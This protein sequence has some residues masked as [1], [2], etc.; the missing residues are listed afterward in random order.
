VETNHTSL[1]AV[2][3]VIVS[4]K[5]FMEELFGAIPFLWIRRVRVFF[6]QIGNVWALLEV[7]RLDAS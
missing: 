1:K 6:L 4:E 7:L 5:L 3:L 2:V